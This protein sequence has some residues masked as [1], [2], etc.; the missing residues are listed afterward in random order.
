MTLSPESNSKRTRRRDD[1]TVFAAYCRENYCNACGTPC[2]GSCDKI[3]NLT[4][5]SYHVLLLPTI[6]ENPAQTPKKEK[7][8]LMDLEFR[9]SNVSVHKKARGISRKIKQHLKQS[10]KEQDLCSITRVRIQ[11]DPGSNRNICDKPSILL[12]YQRIKPIPIGGIKKG[13]TAVYATGKG[14]FPWRSTNGDILMIEML[15]CP[16]ADCTLISPTA[17]A[18][19]YPEV[20]YGWSLFSN[21][22]STKGGLKLLNRDDI[23]HS[24]FPTFME[25]ELWYHYAPNCQSSDGKAVVHSL[26]QR[27][28]FELWHHR[29]GHACPR[30]IENMHKFALG[31]PKLRA[32]P[33]YKCGTC[34]ACKLKKSGHGPSKT[35]EKVPPVP[36]ELF[37]PGLHLYM[38]FGFVRGSSW[39]KKMR[40]V[41]L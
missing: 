7:P 22:D 34:L 5:Q 18:N 3:P 13:Q 4:S 16:D 10:K 12:K 29:L 26:S 20:F 9:L 23:N 8:N 32:P 33:F 24:E 37:R 41:V 15:A 17:I 19:Q 35:T 25:N 30:T 11:N 39:H 28:S 14:F 2:S 6:S 40:K 21:I 1:F 36:E 38:D 31:D 27:A